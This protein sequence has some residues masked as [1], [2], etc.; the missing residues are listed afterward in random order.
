MKT[1]YET[2]KNDKQGNPPNPDICG[3]IYPKLSDDLVIRT[4][5]KLPRYKCGRCLSWNI[6]KGLHNNIYKR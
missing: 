2:D 5:A 4:K 1:L 6:N 3:C